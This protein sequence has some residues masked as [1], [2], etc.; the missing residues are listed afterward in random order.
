MQNVEN[1]LQDDR[2][3]TA[4]WCDGR[5]DNWNQFLVQ[6]I[7][8]VVGKSGSTRADLVTHLHQPPETAFQCLLHFVLYLHTE[9]K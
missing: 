1:Q 3:A 2:M 7:H 8:T 4:W 9:C 5:V 6:H